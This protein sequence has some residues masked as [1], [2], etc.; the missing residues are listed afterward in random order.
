MHFKARAHPPPTHQHKIWNRLMRWSQYHSS[1][2]QTQCL[3]KSNHT[4]WPNFLDMLTLEPGRRKTAEDR[5]SEGKLSTNTKYQYNWNTNTKV[6]V[7]TKSW[8]P[9]TNGVFCIWAGEK[10]RG[11]NI[12]KNKYTNIEV[13]VWR[14]RRRPPTIGGFCEW[15]GPRWWIESSSD[16][17]SLSLGKL[18]ARSNWRRVHA[19]HVCKL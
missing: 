2:C 12:N 4:H 9:P 17:H 18:R 10:Y 19:L 5:N 16:E 7:P 13:Q 14:K 6:Q 3:A 11:Q 15:V 1:N 8:G